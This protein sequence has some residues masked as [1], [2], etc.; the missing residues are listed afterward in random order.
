MNMKDT[1]ANDD[2][3][4]IDYKDKS[5]LDYLE[6]H[7]NATIFH[8]PAWIQLMEKSYG[9]RPYVLVF[10]KDDK[11]RA[12]V[13]FMEIRSLITGNRYVSLPY[14][15]YCQ[16]LYEDDLSLKILT[17]WFN[18]AFQN[19]K[20]PRIQLRWDYPTTGHIKNQKI[21]VNHAIQIDSN[22]ELVAKKLKRTHRQNI[23]TAI[24]RGVVVDQG[25]QLEH[26]RSYYSLQLETRR[27]HGVPAQPW[28]FFNHLATTIFKQGLGF[29]M[30][31]YYESKCIAGVVFLHWKHHLVAKYSAS[32][33][34]AM[35]LRPNN[36]LFWKGI[37]WGCNNG[38]SVFDFGRTEQS[39]QGLCRYKRGWGAEE[40][41]LTYS[42]FSNKP[43]HSGEDFSHK[44]MQSV[45]QKSPI[46]VC[47]LIGELLYRHFG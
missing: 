29:V 21:Y 3:K 34:E 36:L 9:Y 44:M 35:I 45:I 2:V 22:P 24:N 13:P 10:N 11:I 6:S 30:L 5:W 14:T 43:V 41:E 28:S 20:M 12:G 1:K 7:S 37:E 8:H 26:L 19:K 47:R 32:L 39:N 38:F 4:L 42:I 31:A 25:N 33:E 27:R 23:Q 17:D 46:W 15:D 18:E 16:P 40:T